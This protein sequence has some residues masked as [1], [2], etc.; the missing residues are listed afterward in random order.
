MLVFLLWALTYVV[1]TWSA[2]SMWQPVIQASAAI[3]RRVATVVGV[4][5]IVL[6]W[7]AFVSAHSF[8]IS[9]APVT[10]RAVA[11]GGAG[12]Q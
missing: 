5:L 9:H 7:V 8:P 3:R 10:S 11:G 12:L 4:A 6:V 2:S 1:R